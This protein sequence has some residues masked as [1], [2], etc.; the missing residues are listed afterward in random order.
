MAQADISDPQKTD[1]SASI[2]CPLAYSGNYNV[3]KQVEFFCYM[4]NSY[5]NGMRADS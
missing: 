4:W 3:M 5:W 1:V 2:W